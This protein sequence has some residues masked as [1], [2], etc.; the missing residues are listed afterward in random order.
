MF[1]DK[2][3][4]SKFE[5]LF[6]ALTLLM[7][8][9]LIYFGVVRVTEGFGERVY[10]YTS[11][12]NIRHLSDRADTGGETETMTSGKEDPYY[13]SVAYNTDVDEKS[14]EEALRLNEGLKVNRASHH[15]ENMVEGDPLAETH[16]ESLQAVLY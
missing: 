10:I 1:L 8:L 11:G 16:E 7:L 2:I 6:T 4:Q 13:S 15:I 5:G 3:G 9:V 14:A 12:A